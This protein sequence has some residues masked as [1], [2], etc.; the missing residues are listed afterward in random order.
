MLPV[1]IPTVH[2]MEASKTTLSMYNVETNPQKFK[3]AS[4]LSSS[5]ITSPFV[6]DSEGTAASH[7]GSCNMADF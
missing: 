7:R 2:I 4:F 3:S 5:H 6:S 1:H